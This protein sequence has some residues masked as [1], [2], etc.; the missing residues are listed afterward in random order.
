MPVKPAAGRP[1]KERVENAAMRRRQLIEATIDSIVEHGLSATTLATVSDG[2]GLSQGVAV[3]YFKNK[4]TLL[5]ETLKYHYEEYTEV[6][7]SAVAA[8]P[9]DAVEK[10]LAMVGADLD[11]RICNRRHLA[12][13]NSF[14]GE[15]KARPVFAEICDTYDAE[16]TAVLTALC[17]MAEDLIADPSWNAETLAEALATLT[18]GMWIRMHVT[19]DAMDN[20]AGRRMVGR[21]LATLLP[22]RH[23]QVMARMA[24]GKDADNPG[25]KAKAG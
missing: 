23:D 24:G 12:L 17:R 21:F 18:D 1:R 16:H 20:A 25:A 2:A 3:F 14:W 19:P 4:Q 5:A 8:A 6:W 9:D 11:E 13:W 22:A 15:A 7:K 10:I